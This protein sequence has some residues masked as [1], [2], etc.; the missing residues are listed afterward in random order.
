MSDVARDDVDKED[1]SDDDSWYDMSR[2][3]SNFVVPSKYISLSKRTF[4]LL[5]VVA[6]SSKENDEDD[7]VSAEEA[8]SQQSEFA[9]ED[10]W[11]QVPISV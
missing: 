2:F 4:F 6:A 11:C 9:T 8:N 3:V 5:S 10:G 1:D 7:T